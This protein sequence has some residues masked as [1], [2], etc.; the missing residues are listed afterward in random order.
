MKI[1]NVQL[2]FHLVPLYEDKFVAEMVI[3][4][5]QFCMK[6]DLID[7]VFFSTLHKYFRTAKKYVETEEYATKKLCTRFD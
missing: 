2:N 4:Y 3:K 5:Q 7:L 6:S 1:F